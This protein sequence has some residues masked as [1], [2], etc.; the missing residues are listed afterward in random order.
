MSTETILII[1]NMCIS[2]ATPLVL[3]FSHAIKHLESSSC[4]S[5]LGSKFQIK[6]KDDSDDENV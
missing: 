3:A 2:F 1:I 5:C 4:T 6:Q